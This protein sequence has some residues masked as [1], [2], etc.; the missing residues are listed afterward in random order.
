[1]VCIIEITL[2]II[3]AE[4]AD[5]LVGEL[6]KSLKFKVDSKSLNGF[7]FEFSFSNC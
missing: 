7:V 5:N 4:I 1:M 2:S 6:M 3:F